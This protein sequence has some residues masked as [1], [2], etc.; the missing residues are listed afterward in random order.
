M[1]L[2]RAALLPLLVASAALAQSAPAAPPSLNAPTL[3]QAQAVSE[4]LLR[5]FNGPGTQIFYGQIPER[6]KVSLGKDFTVQATFQTKQGTN[7][8]W[9][10]LAT[11]PDDLL[12]VRDRLIP[13][14]QASGWNALDQNQA[15]FV[16]GNTPLY[17][18]FYRAGDANLTMN[19]GVQRVDD[20]TD[21]DLNIGTVPASQIAFYKKN[22]APQSSLPLLLPLPG[23][24]TRTA[25]YGGGGG[26]N[27]T[28]SGVDVKTSASQNE[29]FSHYSA[30]L[31]ARG[32][33]ALTDTATGS[34]RVVTYALTDLNGREALGTLGIRAWKEG[35]YVLTV[36]VQSFKP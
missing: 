13:A 18:N 8:S 32:W 19:I 27:G 5:N 15:G 31:K 20:H 21:I 2:K 36:S 12:T 1:T 22:S 4:R 7:V 24:T 33:K 29:V 26:P 34:L 9:R 6:L 14:L 30:Q 23:T 3:E 10:V 16:G 25:A 11:A 17:G 35:E 28:L